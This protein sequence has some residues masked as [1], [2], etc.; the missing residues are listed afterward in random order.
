M[1]AKPTKKTI[2][3]AIL[4]VIIITFLGWMFNASTKNHRSKSLKSANINVEKRLDALYLK[5]PKLTIPKRDPE[6]NLTDTYENLFP[7]K[8]RDPLGE[9]I[10]SFQQM[11]DGKKP[12]DAQAAREFLATEDS[13]LK[14]LIKKSDVSYHFQQRDVVPSTS[15]MLPA[16]RLLT[17][18]FALQA[19]LGDTSS[20]D[21]HL[22]CPQSPLTIRLP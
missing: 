11:L 9:K 2:P 3:I 20:S 13:R 12:W 8:T 4:M 14:T 18:S 6:K 19:K 10:E 5:Y 7:E 15:F 17:T 16:F 21:H 22:P 1:I